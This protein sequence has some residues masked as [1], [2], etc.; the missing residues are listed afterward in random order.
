[1]S[2]FTIC[3]DPLLS[4]EVWLAQSA[5]G[6]AVRIVPTQR[7]RE[8]VAVVAIGYG[9]TDLGFTA[10]DA[11]AHD[12][13]EGVAHYLEHKLFE[14][15][16]LKVFD[17]FARRGAQVN[18]NTGFTRT[19]Y[20]FSATHSHAETLAD[21]L[22]LVS[23]P[24][25]TAENVD[26]ERGIIAQEIKMYEDSPDYRAFFDLLRCLYRE[27]PVR[28]PVGG[29]VESIQAITPAELLR[30]YGAFYR[31]GNAA[32]AIA[33]PVDADAILAQVDACTLPAGAAPRSR[34][35][36]DLGP[37]V[38]THAARR[39]QVA[40]S[41]LMLGCK[42]PDLAADPQARLRRQ[43]VTRLLLEGLFAPSAALRADL[44]ERGIV[45]D[46]LSYSYMAERSFGFV[47][48]GGESEAPE[49][50]ESE[51]RAALLAPLAMTDDDLERMRRRVIGQYVRSFESARGMAFAHVEQALE[52][53]EPFGLLARLQA[54]RLDDLRARQRE[55]FGAERL[56]AA[57][58]AAG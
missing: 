24:H 20:F 32:L 2:R 48:I 36:A 28:H 58:V 31:T 33:G 3:R 23:K 26:K 30:C 7:F 8:V 1:M 21:L 53:I 55:L 52:G 47:V 54:V 15:E 25:I 16:E 19:N 37:P 34:C 42:D 57:V 35:P 10:D 29:T 4:E 49:L 40:R 27:H 51:L 43:L 12:S 17:R 13:P 9:S 5:Q 11:S 41:R 44:S 38:Q 18:A 39:M 45:D 6:L 50:L 46:S 22:R 14:D 56:A